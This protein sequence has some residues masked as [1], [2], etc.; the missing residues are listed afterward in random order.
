MSSALCLIDVKTIFI[1]LCQGFTVLM[2]FILSTFFV[3]TVRVRRRRSEIY[4]LAT[5]DCICVCLSLAAFPH[6]CTDPDV[7]WT[8][9]RGGAL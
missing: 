5:R 3:F 6:Y 8:N 4:I 1:F 9:G 2:F 7:T